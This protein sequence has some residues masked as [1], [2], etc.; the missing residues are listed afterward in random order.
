MIRRF[1]DCVCDRLRK[2]KT[3]ND[4]HITAGNIVALIVAIWI[5]GVTDAGV[6]ATSVGETAGECLIPKNHIALVA[7]LGPIDPPVIRITTGG[8]ISGLVDRG[9]A[10]PK[11]AKAEKEK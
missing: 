7:A 4:T 9:N 8:D 5:V 10:G 2:D 6:A 3:Q 1:E 11:E